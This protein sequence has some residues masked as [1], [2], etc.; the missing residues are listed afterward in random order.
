MIR[1]FLSK[2][3]VVVVLVFIFVFIYVFLQKLIISLKVRHVANIYCAAFGRLLSMIAL[4]QT[5]RETVALLE[6][7]A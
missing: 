3:T 7:L 5:D 2:N 4:M 6:P 1:S